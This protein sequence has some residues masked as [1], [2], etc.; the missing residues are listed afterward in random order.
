MKNHILFCPHS[1]ADL[2]SVRSVIVGESHVNALYGC[3]I[4]PKRDPTEQEDM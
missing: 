2:L 3:E 4:A 1:I